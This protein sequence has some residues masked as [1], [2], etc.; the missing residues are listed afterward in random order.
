MSASTFAEDSCWY[1][2]R[3]KPKQ[4]ERVFDNFQAWNVESRFFKMLARN[5]NSLTGKVTESVRPLFPRYVFAR[6]VAGEMLH[7]VNFTRGVHGVVCF[8]G[9]PVPVDDEVISLLESGRDLDGLFK[10][11]EEFEV[12]DRIEIKHGHFQGLAGIFEKH[13][14]DSDRVS[15]LLT[16]VTYQGRIQVD[17]WSVGKVLDGR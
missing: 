8:G 10:V 13:L 1:V 2:V 11:R 7:K 9:S 17:R 16:T 5:A 15:I 12:G 14:K 4:E 6:F 3:T